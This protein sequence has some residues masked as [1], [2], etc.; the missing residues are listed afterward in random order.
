M[1][2]Q[3]GQDLAASVN[4]S[5]HREVRGGT[6]RVPQEEALHDNA[7]ATVD[8]WAHTVIDNDK[9]DWAE[10]IKRYDAGLKVLPDEKYLKDKREFCVK[11][12]EK[13]K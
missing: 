8:Q 4:G 13:K 7:V 11:Q 12:A 3:W 9:N 1:Y 6:R 5:R 10:A 2:D